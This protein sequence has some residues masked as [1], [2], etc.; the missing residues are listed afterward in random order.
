[1]KSITFLPPKQFNRLP[2][3]DTDIS[4]GIAD[5]KKGRAYVR[6]SG[7][8]ALDMLIA[9]HELNE[10][11]AKVSPHEENGIRYKKGNQIV[12]M[13]VP[14]V[15]GLATGGLGALGFLGGSTG[16]AGL[17]GS[18]LSA[19]SITPAVVGAGAGALLNKQNPGMGAL[20]GALGG[21]GGGTMGVGAATGMQ[22]AKSLGASQL[23]GGLRGAVG[24][25]PVAGMQP[26][27]YTLGQAGEYF[28]MNAPAASMAKLPYMIP[29]GEA[30]P[31]GAGMAGAS[32][33]GA[34]IAGQSMLNKLGQTAAMS[35][36]Q[37]ALTQPQEK[38]PTYQYV[39]YDPSTYN[40][41]GTSTGTNQYTPSTGYQTLKKM[42]PSSG[43]IPLTTGYSGGE[44]GN[45]NPED[46]LK[47]YQWNKWVY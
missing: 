35:T 41:M 27:G 7:I 39:F 16:L 12:S 22:T 45:E 8:P 40:V 34:G 25:S 15:L 30:L 43:D 31:G 33:I 17:L 3:T 10:L 2:Y 38:T 47:R 13:I 1:M 42:M 5:Y 32:A 21:W 6:K 11:L 14:A 19:T 20:T 44:T 36:A 9:G 29:A 18:A 4:L 23:M 28:G 26:S 24:M 46:I 37:Q